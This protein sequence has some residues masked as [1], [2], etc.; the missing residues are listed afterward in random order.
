MRAY[1]MSFHIWVLGLDTCNTKL[2]MSISIVCCA[3]QEIRGARHSNFSVWIPSGWDTF[4]FKFELNPPSHFWDMHLQSL[5]LF[6]VFSSFSSFRNTFWNHY[7]SR[8]LWWIALSFGALLEHIRTYLRFNFCS[9]RLEKRLIFRNDL[10]SHLQ[11]K[12]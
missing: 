11:V 2:K 10:L 9:N 12:L 3:A 4:N 5:S 8:V 7:N 1:M 6:F